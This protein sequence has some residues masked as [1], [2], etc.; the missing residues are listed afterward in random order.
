MDMNWTSLAQACHASWAL[1]D[2]RD[3]IALDSADA[4][5][6]YSELAGRSGA[7]AAGLRAAGVR[8]GQ[9][10][11]I[12]MERT[13]DAVLAL[14]GILMAGA[15][16]CPLEP[17]LS[18][19]ETHLR[20]AAVGVDWLL[21][22]ASQA[23]YAA[24]LGCKQ[25]L[26]FETIEAA[27]SFLD[28]GLAA[29]DRG[30]LLFTSGSTGRP[31][32]VM[33]SH[34][35][36]LANVAGVI[37]HSALS[38]DDVLLHV[39]PLYHT[40]GLNNQLFAPLL[41]GARVALA[42]RFK[43]DD[44]PALLDRFRPTIITGV[45]TMYSRMLPQSFSPDSLARLRMARCGSAPITPDLQAQVE[46]KLG[47]PLVVSYGLS[48]ATCTSTMNPP[49]RRKIGSVGTV[50]AGQQVCLFE[51]DSTNPVALGAQGEICISGPNLMTGY[52]GADPGQAH[53]TRDGWLHTGDLGRFDED[54]YLFITGRIKDVIIRGG[55]NLSPILIENAI[56]SDP[57]IAAC[58][59]VGKADADLGEVPVAFVI[60]E[61]GAVIDADYVM[62]I[63][64]ARL[65]RIY[66]PQ[67][68]YFVD[69]LPETA[70][71]KIDRKALA[72]QVRAMPAPA[73][74][75]AG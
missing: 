45:P 63:V 62:A 49:T 58:I 38:A 3:R 59:V 11:A 43:A 4:G 68:V 7:I 75:R 2:R 27:D 37:P 54:G 65:S 46:A 74:A 14:F 53:A 9:I 26:A 16:P 18:A 41:A 20:F 6:T 72:A 22:D 15:C 28:D 32:G 50:L 17:R 21:Y 64:T 44:M 25:S 39:M 8:R 34:G 60:P 61:A 52:L 13:P 57:Q 56:T 19:E 42:T 30:L 73:G 10:V 23:A 33:L 35:N 36:L 5:T 40:N 1:A 70:V 12:A 31:K 55:E 29:S 67:E 51:P 66:K 47:C 48:E 71:G 69:K 24:E